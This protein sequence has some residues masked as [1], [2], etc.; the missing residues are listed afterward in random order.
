[1]IAINI[2]IT[3]RNICHIFLE[4]FDVC[5]RM[6]NNWVCPTSGPKILDHSLDAADF[7]IWNSNPMQ[8]WMLNFSDRIYLKLLKIWVFL[9]RKLEIYL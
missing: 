1:M 5:H 9:H 6:S 8:G 2:G 4:S 3:K 7:F